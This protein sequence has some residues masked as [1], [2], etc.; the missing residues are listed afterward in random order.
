MKWKLK[1]D[2]NGNVVLDEQGFPVWVNEKGEERGY[3]VE[4]MFNKITDLNAEAKGHREAKEKAEKML[5]SFNGIDPTAAR[6][7]VQKMQAITDKK[8]YESG[9]V[10][11]LKGEINQTW[12]TK[13]D[14]EVAARQKIE[15]QF[16]EEKIGGAF[17][18]SKFI[19][20]KLVVPADMVQALFARN[21]SLDEAGRVV[22][23]DSKG[24]P[25]YSRKSP[26]EL[27]DF[28]EAVEI[29]VDSYPQRDRIMKSAQAPGSGNRG[30]GGGSNQTTM[31]R[32]QFAA[33]TPAAQAEFAAKG[34]ITD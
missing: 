17:G 15:N 16:R 28:D 24:S 10:E 21:F 26:G 20:E 31:T 32:A 30:N 27:A 19:G 9:D 23:S 12:Q 3:D 13:Y 7:A 14:A 6:E 34:T 18:R 1:K 8:L 29:L 5:E 33:L 2:A 11:K 22:A 4:R 25:I